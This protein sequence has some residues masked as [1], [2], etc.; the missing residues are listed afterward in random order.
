MLNPYYDLQYLYYEVKLAFRR[1][2]H[3]RE[4][5]ERDRKKAKVDGLTKQ[6]VGRYT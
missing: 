4:L 5:L 1:W 2:W 3:R 6:S